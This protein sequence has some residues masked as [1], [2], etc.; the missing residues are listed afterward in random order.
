[1]AVK[2]LVFRLLGEDATASASMA[3]LAATADKSAKGIQSSFGPV[4]GAIALA[5]VAGTIASVKMAAD[6]Q[7]LSTR[8]VTDAGESAKSLGM[9]KSGMLDLS[10]ATGTSAKEIAG[11][12]YIVESAGYHGAQGLAVMKAVAEGA[13]IGM[14]DTKTVA[15]AL[16]TTLTD[17]GKAAGSPAQ[18]MSMLTATVSTG[19]TNMEALAGSLHSVMP[20][21]ASAGISLKELL[22]AVGTMTGEGISADQATQNLNNAISSLMSP[23]Q[24]AQKEMAQMGLSFID[25]SQKLG[26]RGLTGTFQML[27]DAVTQHMGKD[28]LVIQS[29]MNES[30]IAAQSAKEELAQ[31]PPAMRKMGQSFLDNQITQKQWTASLKGLPVETANLGKQFAVTA[32]HAH[33]FSD[34]L[35]GGSGVA[36]TY[37]AAMEKMTGGM[38]GLQVALHLTGDHMGSF[39]SNVDIIGKATS[40][41]HGHVRGWA[42]TQKGF[43]VQLGIATESFKNMGIQFGTALLPGITKV[44]QMFS[45]FAAG[46]RSGNGAAVALAVTIGLVATALG[47][48]YVAQKLMAAGSTLL[49]V[50]TLAAT[51]AQWAYNTALDANPIGII[52]LAIA[53]LVAGLIWFFTQTKLGQ[54]IWTGFVKI[55]GDAWTWLWESVLKPTFTLIGA[56]FTWLWNNIIEPCINLIVLEVKGLGVIFNWL[57]QNVIH[58]VANWIGDAI[59]TVGSVIGAVF[60]AIGNTIQNAFSG[61]VG[62]VKDAINGVIDVIDGAIGGINTLIKGVNSIPGVSVPLLA[63]IPHFAAGGTMPRDGMAL[64][65]EKGPELVQLPGGSRVYPHGTDPG[66]RSGG[67]HIENFYAGTQSP[68]EIERELAWRSRWAT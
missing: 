43:N 54:E 52:V 38:T 15:D 21:A 64:V 7:Q 24:V 16:T 53:A 12:M 13:K 50:G 9:V 67:L 28:G 57:W 46:L 36:Q 44:A 66:G 18:A 27:S 30:K 40:E 14:A 10:S 33:G 55:L 63:T 45:G 60:G 35:K 62:F 8:L 6:F 29:A 49:K 39:K 25:V 65:G 59:N 4:P 37:N 20:A 2:D 1:M 41:A 22:G 19:K 23:S 17:Y 48:A 61:A 42:D 51:A 3:K 32:K 26:Q 34:L 56:I 68:A 5:A 11:G 47:G 31:M 58:P